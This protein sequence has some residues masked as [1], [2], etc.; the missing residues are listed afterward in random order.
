MQDSRGDLT[1]LN[2]IWGTHG[3][4]ETWCWSQGTQVMHPTSVPYLRTFLRPSWTGR[5]QFVLH[6]WQVG[7]Y[8]WGPWLGSKIYDIPYRLYITA[9]KYRFFP[10]G[11]TARTKNIYLLWGCGIENRGFLAY[12]GACQA[13]IPVRGWCKLNISKVRGWCGSVKLK[14]LF[15]AADWTQVCT[16]ST[17]I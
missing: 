5:N 11:V 10:C 16:V 13:K 8:M 15:G 3:Q 2:K 9:Q 6:M 17:F 1:A 4:G 7:S 14:Y 12:F